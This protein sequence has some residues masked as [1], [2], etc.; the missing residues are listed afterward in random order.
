LV[1]HPKARFSGDHKGVALAE[2]G[3]P[4]PPFKQ[5]KGGFR[6]MAKRHA[7]CEIKTRNNIRN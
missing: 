7:Y 6:G 4:L 5:G 2:K 1:R 3:P